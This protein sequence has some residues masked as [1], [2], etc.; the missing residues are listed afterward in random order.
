ML[1]AAC[2]LGLLA[3]VLLA[4]GGTLGWRYYN[5]EK[6]LE[7]ERNGPPVVDDTTPEVNEVFPDV[8]GVVQ[9]K[10]VIKTKPPG[11]RPPTKADFEYL[12]STGESGLRLLMCNLTDHYNIDAPDPMADPFG[13]AKN[14]WRTVFMSPD[15]SP[16]DR[17]IPLH[18]GLGWYAFFVRDRRGTV[19]PLWQRDN[20]GNESTLGATNVFTDRRVVLEIT[21]GSFNGKKR[22]YATLHREN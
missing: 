14:E 7:I 16:E 17:K 20:N 2:G 21:A 3:L 13:L 11:W 15:A 10:E 19:W 1:A 12:N 5:A 4:I 8:D 6:D 18:I 22:Y 9:N